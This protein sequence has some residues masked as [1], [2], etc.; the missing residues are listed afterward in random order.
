MR[1]LF[2]SLDLDTESINCKDIFVFIFSAHHVEMR[3]LFHGIDPHLERTNNSH[4]KHSC[5]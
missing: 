1:D 4:K 2:D 5:I 3:N